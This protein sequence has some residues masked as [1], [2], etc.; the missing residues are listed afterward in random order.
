[1]AQLIRNALKIEGGV[2]LIYTGTDGRYIGE[3]I[4]TGLNAAALRAIS[5]DLRDFIIEEQAA[6]EAADA[7]PEPPKEPLRILTRQ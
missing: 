4:V 5:E 6:L 7:P 2:R 3:V 1:M